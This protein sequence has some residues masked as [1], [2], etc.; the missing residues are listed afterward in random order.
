VLLAEDEPLVAALIANA[1]RKAGYTVLEARRGEPALE[2]VRAHAGVIDLLLTDVVMPGMN[3][4]ELADL[5][6]TIRPETRVLYM[7]GYSDDAMLR[8]GV[9]T[10]SAHFIQKPFSMEALKIK[11]RETLNAAVVSLP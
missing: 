3:G 11:L 7:S 4:R 9:E 10:A 8:R 2:I 6:K 1:L 5:I